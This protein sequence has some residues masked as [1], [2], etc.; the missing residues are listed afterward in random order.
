MR[1]SLLMIPVILLLTVL[2]S[3]TA[4]ADSIVTNA[5]GFVDGIDD[6]TIAGTTYDVTFGGTEDITF[7]SSLSNAETAATDIAS[8]LVPYTSVA[9]GSFNL[10]TL[11]GVDGGGTTPVVTVGN[12][13]YGAEATGDYVTLADDNPTSAAWAEFDV[14]ATPEPGAA[15]LTLTGLGLFGLLVVL[16]K[17]VGPRHTQAA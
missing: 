16:R 6:V 5:G 14:V 1:K 10:V 11:V 4:S 15:T 17:R 13:G 9:A 2:G 8:D 3:R 7:S 12:A